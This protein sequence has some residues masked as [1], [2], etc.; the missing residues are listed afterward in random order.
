MTYEDDRHFEIFPGGGLD[1]GLSRGPWK[2]PAG[3]PDQ[4]GCGVPLR[5]RHDGFESQCAGHQHR[6]SWP[7]PPF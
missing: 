3:K 4:R 1:L 6:S 7:R 5:Q 2:L